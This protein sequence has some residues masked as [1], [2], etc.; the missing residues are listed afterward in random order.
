MEYKL[1]SVINT[2]TT[3]NPPGT[4][5]VHPYSNKRF[6]ILKDS[7]QLENTCVLMPIEILSLTKVY[8][9]NPYTM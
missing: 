3:R 7:F 4:C 2:D 1:P 8:I 6:V 9:L 5:E